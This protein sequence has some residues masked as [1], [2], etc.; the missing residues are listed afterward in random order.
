MDA[1]PGLLYTKSMLFPLSWFLSLLT[2]TKPLYGPF[3]PA[4]L[5]YSP[6]PAPDLCLLSPG[7]CGNARKRDAPKRSSSLPWIRFQVTLRRL[8]SVSPNPRLTGCF[9]AHAEASDHL[10]SV[11]KGGLSR[12]LQRQEERGLS[13]RLGW[14]MSLGQGISRKRVAPSDHEALKCRNPGINGHLPKVTRV[15]CP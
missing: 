14:T 9:W 4:R 15:G 1:S 7:C 13:W 2:S 6:F 8:L 11:R 5:A 12:G 3:S 10:L